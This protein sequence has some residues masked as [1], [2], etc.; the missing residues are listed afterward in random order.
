MINYLFT[1]IKSDLSI[2]IYQLL[3]ISIG[4]VFVFVT[5]GYRN[6]I[7]SK[8]ES[9]IKF[10]DNSILMTVGGVTPDFP[11]G[12][13]PVND[14]I[15]LVLNEF[16]NTALF[17]NSLEFADTNQSVNI[18]AT[19]SKFIYTG[20]PV[21]NLQYIYHNIVENIVIIKGNVWTINTTEYVTVID[22]DTANLVFGHINVIG[23]KIKMFDI[24]FTIIGVASN[25][26]FRS[27][28][29]SDLSKHG[30]AVDLD[31][32]A[33]NAYIPINTYKNI[34]NT[35]SVNQFIIIQDDNPIQAKSRLKIIFNM[36]ADD[37]FLIQTKQFMLETTFQQ[38]NA[39]FWI[40][41][42]VSMIFG[43][44][45]TLNIINI[46]SYSYL[47]DKR[48]IGIYKLIGATDLD[49]LKLNLYETLITSTFTIFGSLILSYIILIIMGII[50]G[51]LKFI[52]WSETIFVAM[53]L[54]IFTYLLILIINTTITFVHFNKKSIYFLHGEEK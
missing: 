22:E 1:K 45:G 19:T 8:I 10:K 16:P 9:D 6:G 5:L 11:E 48:R 27:Q 30:Q 25:T 35:D 17:Y 43:I 13:Y 28:Q 24:E 53:N 49:I 42:A 40:I 41:A 20:V 7:I 54:F 46:S 31:N 15:N 18:I 37:D 34:K 33:T 2:Y 50:N 47:S 26:T 51:F 52:N 4:I 39:L 21:R 12:F 36:K 32:V 38:Y 14:Q 29:V 44:L 23:Y 3:F